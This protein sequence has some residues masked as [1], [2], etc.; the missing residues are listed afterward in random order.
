MRRWFLIVVFALV[1]LLMGGLLIYSQYIEPV[2]FAPNVQMSPSTQ[3]LSIRTGTTFEGLVRQL[4]SLGIIADTASF[5]SC[6]RYLKY[7]ARVRPGQYRLEDGWSNLTLVRLLRSG[8][9]SPIKLVIHNVR[10]L[11]E[12]AGKIGHQI[13]PD[14]L[15]IWDAF[16][17]SRQ[18]IPE[19]SAG[20]DSLMCLFLPNTYEV[21]WTIKPEELLVRMVEEYNRFW[22]P[23]RIEQATQ[24][25]YTPNQIYI[26]ASI[27]EKE[28]LVKDEKATIARVYLNRLERG[29]PLQADPTVVFAKGD[30]STGRVL[31]SDLEIDSPYNTYKYPG[32]P[33][34]P[35]CMPEPGT[36]LA[37][38]QAEKHEYI[39]F[40]AKPDRSGR[41]TF[42]RTLAAH[43]AN[44]RNYQ[45]WLNE[46]RIFR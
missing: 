13:E 38:L 33:P 23:E 29:I 7:G 27:V 30:F 26:L 17:N 11:D 10:T 43:N 31:F 6:A 25:G 45:H 16:R 20:E 4:D 34:G 36:I 40:C 15:E 3:R 39:Y 2:F 21:Y 14:S 41:H 35:I 22:T 1:A 46:Q 18:I 37:T 9:Q 24:A 42:A 12:L 5:T 32:L 8:A 19:S 44:A 28:T